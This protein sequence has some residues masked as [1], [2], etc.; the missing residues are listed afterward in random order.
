MNEVTEELE[1]GGPGEELRSGQ[2][3]LIQRL[4]IHR[5]SSRSRSR[6]AMRDA[7]SEKVTSVLGE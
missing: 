3:R 1:T 7:N 4:T 6:K 5:S 2:R